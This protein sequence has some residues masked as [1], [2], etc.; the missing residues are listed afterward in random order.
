MVGLFKDININNLSEKYLLKFK[1][2]NNSSQS[3]LYK[4]FNN[5]V[6]KKYN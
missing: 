3:K 1:S 5:F 6:T 2:L 4:Q